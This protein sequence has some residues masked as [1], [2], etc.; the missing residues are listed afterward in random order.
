M[1]KKNRALRKDRQPPLG[2]SMQIREIDHFDSS[3]TPQLTDRA[4]KEGREWVEFTQL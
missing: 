4:V 3:G 2:L 1:K